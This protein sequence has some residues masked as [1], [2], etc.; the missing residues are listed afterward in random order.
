MPYQTTII[1][2][3]RFK[4]KKV[5]WHILFWIFYIV[6]SV[7]RSPSSRFTLWDSLLQLAYYLPV[8]VISSYFIIYMVVRKYLLKQ[9]YIRFTVYLLASVT[10]F[11]LINRAIFYYVAL[12]RFYPDYIKQVYATGFFHP[13]E[14]VTFTISLLSVIA[15][16]AA[17]TF[18]TEW[19]DHERSR[20]QLVKEKL[21]S[22]L[23]FLKSQIHPHF[24]FNMLNN[25]YA[26]TLKKSDLA[27]SMILKISSLLDYMLHEAMAPSVALHREI[28][29]LRDYI[30]L[31]KIRYGERIAIDLDITG[32]FDGKRIAPLLLLPFL[33]N[34]FKHG[35]S[36]DLENPW[37][38]LAISVSDSVFS[39]RLSNSVSKPLNNNRKGET[40]G[41][42]FENVRRR[43]DLLYGNGYELEVLADEK[44]YSVFLEVQLQK[45]NGESA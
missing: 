3:H 1:P 18:I 34:S 33:E 23:M 36:E 2:S 12:P 5:Y 13:M 4:W 41:I 20:Q 45:F 29:V 14:L 21:E 40:A 37:V 39:M 32:E 22:E 35:A 9:N 25:L 31:E 17:I 26:L 24:L 43:L 8:L 10:G 6:L 42:G 19:Y 27:P 28:E 44:Q 15:F 30:E 11:A 16:V 38:E 7:V